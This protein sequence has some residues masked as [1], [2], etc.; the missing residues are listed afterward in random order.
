MSVISPPSQ[1]SSIWVT[2]PGPSAPQP[3]VG[4]ASSTRHWQIITR[5]RDRHARRRTPSA[6][7]TSPASKSA[8][9]TKAKATASALGS[10]NPGAPRRAVEAE[11]FG[12][13]FI[14]TECRTRAVNDAELFEDVQGVLPGFAGCVEIGGGVV[15]V[16]EVVKSGGLTVAVAE[17]TIQ[18]EGLLEV[19][20]GL[21][22]VT[23][24]MVRIPEAVQRPGFAAPVAEFPEQGKGKLA[25]GNG[26]LVLPK[27]RVIPAD[28]VQGSGLPEATAGCAGQG[29]GLLGVRECLFRTTLIAEHPA[30]G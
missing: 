5:R 23:K 15:R 27:Q 19:C 17:F 2:H 9:A 29:K 16:A 22:V 8:P 30:E 21:L 18:T 7:I 20:G 6:E 24:V 4:A 26:L 13:D 12:A 3:S 1:A 14:C 10:D 28:T 11:K 25:A